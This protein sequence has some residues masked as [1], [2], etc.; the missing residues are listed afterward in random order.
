MFVLNTLCD[1]FMAPSMAEPVFE[2]AI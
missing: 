1:L 2:A